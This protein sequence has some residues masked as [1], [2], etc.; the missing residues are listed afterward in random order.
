M[1]TSGYLVHANG[2]DR[3]I[4]SIKRTP[5]VVRLTMFLAT[6]ANVILLH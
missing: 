5:F 1:A 2:S 3:K 6:V 4:S